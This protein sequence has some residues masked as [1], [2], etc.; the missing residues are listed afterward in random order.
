MDGQNFHFHMPL[1]LLKGDEGDK[2]WRIRGLASTDRR[3]L[4][5]EIVKQEGLDITAL[6]AGRGIFNYDHREGPENIIGIIEDAA[7]A[8]DGLVVEGYLLKHQ[9]RAKA[10]YDIMRSLKDKDAR[11]VQMSIEGKVIKR[12]EDGKTIAQAKIDKIALTLD[13][14]NE[15]TYAEVVKSVH[16]YNHPSEDDRVLRMKLG[17]VMKCTL[18]KALSAGTGYTDAP[19]TRSGGEALSSE[20]LEGLR[21]LKGLSDTQRESLISK[22]AATI[23]EEHPEWLLADVY[24]QVAERVKALHNA[25]VS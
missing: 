7:M 8:E 11:R 22:I 6:Q 3:D 5:N 14:V 23:Q 18:L 9:D 13:P 19:S 24:K 20:H 15:D 25:G 16:A 2:E 17:L 12:D 21:D 1:E 10:F 4:Q